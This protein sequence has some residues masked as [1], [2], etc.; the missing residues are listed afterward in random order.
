MGARARLVALGVGGAGVRGR[1]GG[2]GD[3]GAEGLEVVDTR[4]V[5]VLRGVGGGVGVQA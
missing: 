2:G 3:E 4:P 5:M 1:G